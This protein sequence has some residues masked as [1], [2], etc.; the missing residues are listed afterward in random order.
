MNL[1]MFFEADYLG[2]SLKIILILLLVYNM[3]NII[4]LLYCNIGV[5][6]LVSI[7][8]IMYRYSFVSCC[9]E[10]L[11]ERIDDNSVESP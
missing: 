11:P 9:H 7:Y 2:D 5:T 3:L 1:T 4:L 6:C 10:G 8:N